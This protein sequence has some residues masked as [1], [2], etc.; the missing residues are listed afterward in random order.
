MEFPCPYDGF[1]QDPKDCGRFYRCHMGTSHS[2]DCPHGLYF[3]ENTSVCNHPQLVD[4][5][6]STK[7]LRFENDASS[8][9]HEHMESKFRSDMTDASS[10]K[11][12]CYFSS[13]AWLRDGD[14]SFIPENIP[15]DSCTHVLYAYAG[16]DPIN[17]LLQINDRWTDQDNSKVPLNPDYKMQIPG[18]L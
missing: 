18:H 3:D 16:L 15:T 17:L 13:W 4:C 8:Q 9:M 11:V 2:F 10:H 5:Q 6:M 1:F 14:A 12:V 7:V